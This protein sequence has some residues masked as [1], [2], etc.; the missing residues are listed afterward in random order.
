ML[1][2]IG[3]SM[4]YFPAMA[5]AS[6]WFQ[7]RRGLAMGC[8]ISGAGLGG[9][10]IAPMSRTLIS[11]YE[12]QSALRVTGGAIFV[13]LTIAT[14]LV[15]TRL[16][17]SGEGNL[18]RMV[19]GKTLNSQAFIAMS[20]A[21][22]FHSAGYLVPMYFMS[23]YTIASVTQGTPEMG[24]MLIGIQHGISIIGEH[25]SK[26]SRH[27]LFLPALKP[28]P[29]RISLG[30]AADRLGRTNVLLFCVLTSALSVLLIW[31]FAH[32]FNVMLVFVMFYGLSSGAYMSLFPTV[33]AD[34]FGLQKFP[35]IAGF[36]Y[37]TRG[38]GSF[39]GSPVAGAILDASWH[40]NYTPVILYD[41]ALLSLAVVSIMWLKMSQPQAT[42]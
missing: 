42:S 2:G 4:V 28:L 7:K 5:A 18:R 30:Y 12:W 39:F 20:S 8:V 3:A 16:P 9:L 38:V 11:Q 41:G 13:L 23:T 33:I 21:S 36:L 17:P 40:E 10:I 31:P 29:G 19:D 26:H 24:A 14:M 6:Q 37:F 32:N 35:S 27:P 25:E 22:L 15:K 34:I 1:V